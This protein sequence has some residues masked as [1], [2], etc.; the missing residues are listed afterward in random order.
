MTDQ[1]GAKPREAMP[2]EERIEV[3][4][5]EL[6]LAIKWRQPC[7][8]L[9]VYGS[10]NI[11]ADVQAALSTQLGDLKQKTAWLKFQDQDP[12]GIVESLHKFKEP[13]NTVFFI[14]G[15]C[16]RSAKID[17]AHATLN[18]QQEFLIEGRVRVILWLTQK[19]I[20]DLARH[21]PDFW[22]HR[23]RV[24]EFAESP[25]SEAQLQR[26]V[27]SV[28]QDVG[29]HAAEKAT[30]Q[31]IVMSG[32]PQDRESA[33][34]G[35]KLLLTLGIL[36]WRKGDHEKAE[37]L[38]GEALKIATL[39]QDTSFE[40]ECFNAIALLKTSMQKID[41]AIDAYKQ[42]IQLAPAQ[43]FAWNNLGNLC[44][45]IGRNDEAIVVF[46]KA[47]EC[48]PKD[49]IGWNGLGNVYYKIG[50][51]D[52]AVAAYRRS[53]QFMPTFAHPWNGL[54]DVHASAGRVDQA[55]ASYRKAI[56]LNPRYVAPWQRLGALFNGQA[57]PREALKAYQHAL[58]LEP[59]NAGIWNELGSLHLKSEAYAEAAEA[60]SK[61]IELDHGHGWAHCNLA[62]TYAQ[63]GKHAEAVPLLLR[64]I[65]LLKD[66]KDK[67]VA[68][69]R[70]GDVY[71]LLNDYERA[72]TAYQTADRANLSV[73][74]PQFAPPSADVNERA[75][76]QTPALETVAEV[77]PAP[78]EAQT[79]D[80]TAALNESLL[81]DAPY[82]I[83][84][85]S[86]NSHVEVGAADLERSPEPQQPT[87]GSMPNSSAPD[88]TNEATEP[89]ASA[90][91]SLEAER[92]K[93]DST[94]PL[95]WNEKGNVHFK[96]QDFD[97]AISAY[98][99]AIQLD[100]TFGWPYANL[101]LAYLIQGQF[102][103]A[104]LLYQKSIELLK[105]EGDK[106]LAWNGLGNVYRYLND[107]GNAVAAYQKAAELDPQTAGMRD[108]AEGFQIGEDAQSLDLWNE[109]GELFFKTG[110]FTE[111]IQAFNKAI[112]LEPA[113]G[114][115]YNN[116]AYVLASRG[117]YAQAIPLYE[118]SL[119]LL[120]DSK[121]EA[122]VWNRLGNVYRKLNDYD[123]AMRAYQQAVKLSDDGRTLLNR[124]R[125]SLLS[126]VQVD[127]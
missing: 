33:S 23:Q 99:R 65:E 80:A 95:V 86:S 127:Q 115:A 3:L 87:G 28:W 56:E 22:T 124:T 125:F 105:S 78:A 104:I 91:V 111:A 126:N 1:R 106:A 7:V 45:S 77:E 94:N 96:Q 103:E 79:V 29:A 21:A 15:M 4:A 110:A 53:I 64:S 35:A 10:D 81:A 116:L 50:Y 89:A 67:A 17:G 73:A 61:A 121:D 122:L 84:N 72:V 101:A 30:A 59:R 107:Y 76:N 16:W 37:E 55:L 71:R 12:E 44:A 11:R 26:T 42:A 25:N 13:E 51:M 83:F 118:K 20:L 52:D 6:E 18:L 93:D 8:L 34:N 112:E 24:I 39:S 82:W 70:L 47:I 48:N 9:A 97:P 14:D 68:Y 114:W 108:G 92:I 60:L 2:L 32:L 31:N 109:L 74:L 40:A 100:P 98:N 49:P 62:L 90:A 66:E 117:Q 102:A 41:E 123:N 85:P 69:N 58:S 46:L 63:Q 75:E 5:H 43:I 88:L 57:R 36:N 54:G 120:Q 113:S 19:E 27:D 38:L 119:E